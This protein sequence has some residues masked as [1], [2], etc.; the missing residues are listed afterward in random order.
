MWIVNVIIVPPQLYVFDSNN[1]VIEI[2]VGTRNFV[3]ALKTN[4]DEKPKF[5]K[6]YQTQNFGGIGGFKIGTRKKE[7][8]GVV[9]LVQKILCDK[10]DKAHQNSSHLLVWTICHLLC[11]IPLC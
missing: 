4:G 9:G 6:F 7:N 3:P 2:F 1:T 10:D 8:S 11:G 5:W